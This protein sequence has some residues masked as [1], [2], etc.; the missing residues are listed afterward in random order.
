[1]ILGARNL[2]QRMKQVAVDEKYSAGS[3]SLSFSLSTFS[4]KEC[5]LGL[6]LFELSKHLK[7]KKK[8][9]KKG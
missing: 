6:L 1:M 2:I 7:K 8:K 4:L 5:M 3:R 9:K